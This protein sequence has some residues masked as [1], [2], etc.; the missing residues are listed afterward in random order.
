M[1]SLA[2]GLRRRTR[3]PP[4]PAPPVYPSV[5]GFAGVLRLD[6]A[7]VSPVLLQEMGDRIAHRGPD[8]SGVYCDGPFGLAFRRLAILDLSAMGHQ[9]MATSDGQHVIVFN[10]EIFNFVELREE[11]RQLGHTF[12]ST[13]DTEVLLA[14]YRQ[15]GRA[16]LPK[17]NGM[18]AFLIHDRARQLIFGARDRFGVK[19]LFRRQTATEIA[20]AS[21]IKAFSAIRPL[22]VNHDRL[23]DLA[24]AGRMD[25]LPWSTR[26]FFDG[27]DDVAPGTAFEIDMGGRTNTWSWWNLSDALSP[28]LAA[29]AAPDA[30]AELF[31]DAVAL[32]MRSDVPVGVMLSGGLDSTSIACAMARLAGPADRRPSP[33]HAFMFE[34]REHDETAYTRETLSYMQATAHRLHGRDGHVLADLEHLLH[35][36]DEPV[37]SA[38][39][40]AG[41]WLYALAAQ[42][43]VRVVLGG[44]GADEILAGYS[45]YSRAYWSDLLRQG[46]LTL[47]QS[48][49]SA[50]RVAGQA[51][52]QLATV[53]RRV[54]SNALRGS[55]A[56]RF[57]ISHGKRQVVPGWARPTDAVV[58]RR[59]QI[60]SA[61]DFLSLDA[62][63]RDGLESSPL[64][65]Y[66]RVEDRNA[67]AHS[68][69]ARLP[70]LDYRIVSR[71]FSTP[72]EQKISGFQTKML[73][74]N[75]MRGRIPDSVH[76]RRDKMGF[77][78][79]AAHW[80][81]GELRTPT[82]DLLA[83]RSARESE[84]FNIVGL[85]RSLTSGEPLSALAADNLF[86]FL[87]LNLFLGQHGA[88]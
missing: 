47:L 3:I 10:G 54:T 34:D 13:G 15:W 55:P 50:A 2:R 30:F 75:A 27:V 11:L 81:R 35:I 39:A 59:A 44:Q 51:D 56:V 18:F 25:Q 6:G 36:H 86:Q 38:T 17:L 65:L 88:R 83:S 78:A 69:E 64:R 68:V 53:V 87:Q 5:C 49:L 61:Q 77:P 14:G 19:P 60:T 84:L 29:D 82:L 28:P 23:L 80:F 46:N 26:T 85:T 33:L 31:E 37:H 32:R 67:M 58:R 57:L 16:L 24:A 4:L 71:A 52:A 70:F 48:E 8:D 74:R 12:R 21:E 79:S 62:T 7:A 45:F 63:L 40:L 1:S 72:N 76:Q 43:N 9:P 66:L 73:L 42:Q 22:S 20:F 41:Y